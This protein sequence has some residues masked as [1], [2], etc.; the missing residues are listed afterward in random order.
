M[1]RPVTSFIL[2]FFA[3]AMFAGTLPAQSRGPMVSVRAGKNVAEG[4]VLAADAQTVILLRPSGAMNIVER[5]RMDSIEPSGQS[6]AAW[7]DHEMRTQLSAEFGADY[8]VSRTPHFFVV[9]PHGSYQKWAA[10]FEELYQRFRQYFSS[11]G[12]SLAEP[13]FAM[14]AVVLNSREEFDWFLAKHQAPDQHVLGY[15]APRSNRIITYQP[16]DSAADLQDFSTIVHEATHQT[17]Y[18]TGIHS[19]FTQ[20]PRWATEGLAVMFESRGVNNSAWFGS[21]DERVHAAQL[22]ELMRLSSGSQP[23]LP[24]VADLIARDDSF[25]SSP[26]YSYALAWGLTF[27]LAENYPQQ[28]VRYL[29]RMAA[30]ENFQNQD[31]NQRLEDF[32][33]AFNVRIEELEQRMWL[34][35]KKL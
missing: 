20:T 3:L 17:A 22:G 16:T 13:E 4:A 28:Y 23:S 31:A 35:L 21:R 1:I 8:A 7:G 5:N 15:Y 29:E 9:H 2:P 32:A 33:S 30:V 25:R 24:T 6:F 12:V 26:G 11:R 19:R 14:V 34:Y 10:P 27:Y 18:N